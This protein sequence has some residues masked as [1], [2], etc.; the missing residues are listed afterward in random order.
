MHCPA[1]RAAP[2]AAGGNGPFCS[3]VCR[4]AWRARRQASYATPA[5]KLPPD[6]AGALATL[7][8]QNDTP[9]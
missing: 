3:A 7:L 2:P 5:G 4:D 6:L 8:A 1:C 9:A